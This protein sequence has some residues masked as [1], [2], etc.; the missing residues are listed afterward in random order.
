MVAG[1]TPSG[2]AETITSRPGTGVALTRAL[3][4]GF[5]EPAACRTWEKLRSLV[6]SRPQMRA[7][8][9]LRR[10]KSTC[11]VRRPAWAYE[12]A[13]E[14][15]VTYLPSPGWVDMMSRQWLSAS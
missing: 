2:A 4:S 1:D 11:S 8:R 6:M 9:G 15:D 5:S 12:I 10:S 14:V 3:K 7:R 13:S